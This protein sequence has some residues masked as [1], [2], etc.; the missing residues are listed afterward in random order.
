MLLALCTAGLFL[1]VWFLISIAERKKPWLCTGC[2]KDLAARVPREEE[3][4][5]S[6]P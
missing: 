4:E 5:E 3:L 1:I 2:A 6:I